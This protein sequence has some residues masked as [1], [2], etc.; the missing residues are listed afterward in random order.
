MDNK[1]MKW[2]ILFAWALLAVA[3]GMFFS[4]VCAKK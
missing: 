3:A 2:N 4:K 1:K